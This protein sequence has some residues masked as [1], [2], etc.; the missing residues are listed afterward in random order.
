MRKPG[1]YRSDSNSLNVR[2]GEVLES[3]R[4]ECAAL[5]EQLRDAEQTL[6]TLRVGQMEELAVRERYQM[7]LS[8]APEGQDGG[9]HEAPELVAVDQALN[10][11]RLAA[12]GLMES[13]VAAHARAEAIAERLQREIDYRIQAESALRDSEQRYHRI[14]EAIG[15]VYWLSTAD[16]HTILYFDPYEKPLVGGERAV[17]GSR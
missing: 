6:A 13:A 3:L 12:L 5:R 15:S 2:P 7:L 4:T 9:G 8:A 1:P 17:A 10:K 11:A 14:V 16:W